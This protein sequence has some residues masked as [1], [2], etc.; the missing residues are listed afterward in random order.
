MLPPSFN[1]QWLPILKVTYICSTV[2]KFYLSCR[3]SAAV[4]PQIPEERPSGKRKQ[5]IPVWIEWNDQ[6]IV[7][8]KWVR[9]SVLIIE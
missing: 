9:P 8:E 3:S 7:N 1:H 6:D 2:L 5:S 4:P